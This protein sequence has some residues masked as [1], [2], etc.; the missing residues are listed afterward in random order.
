MSTSKL[1]VKSH[2]ARDLQQSAAFFKNE[3]LV[4]WEYVSNGLQYVDHGTTPVVHVKL[5]SKKKRIQIQDNGRG[6]SFSDLQNFFVMHGENVDRKKGAPGR[7]RFGTGKSAAFGIGQTLRVTTVREGKRSVVELTRDGI[8]RMG[9]EDPI[10]VTVIEKEIATDEKNGTLV[11]IE[12]IHLRSLD[13]RAVITFIERHLARWPKKNYAVF[14]DNHECEV[15]EPPVAQTRTFHPG[16]PETATLGNVELVIKVSKTPLDVDLRG[17]SIYANG[18]WHETTL[19]GAEGKEM[20]QY[21]FGEIDVP[22]LD[23]DKS[24]PAPFDMSRSMTLNVENELVRA[25]HAFV[26]RHINE[27]RKELAAEEKKRRD[28]EEA[29]KLQ[30]EASKIAQLLNEDFQDFKRKL[31]KAKATDPGGGDPQP[32]GQGEGDDIFTTGGEEPV[33]ETYPP[34]TDTPTERP[35]K[36]PELDPDPEGEP[37]GKKTPGGDTGKQKP[38]GGFRVDFDNM[39]EESARAQ[40][41]PDNRTIFINLEHPQIDAAKGLGDIEDPAF[42]RLSYEVAFSEYAVALASELAARDEFFD[43][44]DP[45]G[46]IRDTINRLARKGAKLYVE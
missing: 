35:G 37:K 25:I 7:G 22:A 12:G 11:E 26:G 46:A 17:V 5:D 39:G 9:S 29:R 45:I 36:P 14:V 4:V 10:P 16:E 43:I 31:A 24:I 33:G 8:E 44:T 40:Y 19:A 6:M 27:V 2:V 20:I 32:A 21:I 30:E 1:F 13:S 42:K 18:V 3:K 34:Q 23:D 15:A 28:S 41:V 38:R